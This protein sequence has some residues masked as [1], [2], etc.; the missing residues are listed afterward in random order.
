MGGR[1]TLSDDSHGIDQVGL[2]YERAWNNLTRS[3]I[4][5]LY[6]LAP[7]SDPAKVHDPRFPNVCWEYMS[8]SAAKA[9]PF[10]QP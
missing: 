6:Y 4:T 8:V 10:F 3:G 7:T 9:H 2:N 5:R 1:F